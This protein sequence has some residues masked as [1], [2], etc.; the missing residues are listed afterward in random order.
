MVAV[1]RLLHVDGHLVCS[2][3]TNSPSGTT[4]TLDQ[5]LPVLSK[6]LLPFRL[7]TVFNGSHAGVPYVNV[8]VASS[9]RGPDNTPRDTS[10][11]HEESA[12]LSV[13]PQCTAFMPNTDF[14]GGDLR[15]IH[16]VATKEDCCALCAN[17]TRCSGGSWDG[18]ESPWSDRTC[19]LK[20]STPPANK[21]KAK[22]MFAFTVRSPT[23]APAPPPT[24]SP[25]PT[26]K[27]VPGPP[28]PP[29][30]F[31]PDLPE[32]EVRRDQ[33]QAGLAEGWGLWY[34]MSF[35]SIR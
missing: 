11:A 3:G 4:I 10:R 8:T 27:P 18:P 21:R 16:Q 12:S 33:M 34:Q 32:V 15:G 1:A 20:H 30:V 23:P 7:S 2:S 13:A 26:P 22:G 6:T 9:M 17:D 5:P 29:S 19:N 31:A 25:N 35:V 14:P 28:G 24:P